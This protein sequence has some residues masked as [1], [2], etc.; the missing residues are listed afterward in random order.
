MAQAARRAGSVAVNRA[1]PHFLDAV[2]ELVRRTDARTVL[3]YG[4]GEGLQ[5]RP[6]PIVI[7]GRQVAEGIGEYWDVDEV[8]CYDPAVPQHRTLPRERVDGVVCIDFLSRAPAGDLARI[9]EE[10]FTL[11][12]RFVFAH[13]RCSEDRSLAWWRAL[14]KEA[15]ARHGGVQWVLDASSPA[16]AGEALPVENRTAGTNA[17]E[18]AYVEVE[19]EGRRLRYLTPNALAAGRARTLFQ[20]EP[21]TIEWIR[22]FE[23]GTTLLDIGANVG[24][25]SILAAASRDMRVF[26]F[27]PEG[28]NFALLNRNIAANRLDGKVTAFCAAVSDRAALDRLYLSKLET[29]TSCHSFGAEVGF[30]L[31]PRNAGFVQGCVSGSIDAWIAAGA[32]PVPQYVKIDVDGFEH[33][34]VAGMRQTLEDRRLRQLLV[35]VNTALAPHRDMLRDLDAAGFRFDARQVAGSTRA[36]GPFKGVAEYVFRR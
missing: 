28:Q 12:E 29:G 21:V 17:P 14:F 23:R 19:H 2:R 5:Y 35:E 34:V 9:V 13:V 30:D 31:Q 33:G 4:S 24:M 27:E 11:A 18:E 7:D 22:A 15:A 6:Q 3:D 20:K 36:S 16:P 1:W 10:M 32:L 25:Y 26:A 8:L